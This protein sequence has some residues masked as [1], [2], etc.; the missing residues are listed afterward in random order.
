MDMT[1]SLYSFPHQFEP[2]LP[3]KEMDVLRA[4]ASQVVEQSPRL[5]A[6]AHAA[7]LAELRVLLREMNSYY[8]NHIEGQ[9]THPY[10][11]RQALLKNFFFD[12]SYKSPD[13]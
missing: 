8:S 11:I 1:S 3:Q 9:G 7:T 2:L 5:G 6:M 4:K 13:Q 10:R 12:V